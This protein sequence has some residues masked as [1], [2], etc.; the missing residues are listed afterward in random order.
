PPVR[1]TAAL[2]GCDGRF[3]YFYRV[4]GRYLAVREATKEKRWVED[5]GYAAAAST[6]R[7]YEFRRGN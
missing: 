7:L 4:P 1:P 6:G 3:E 2:M 5:D